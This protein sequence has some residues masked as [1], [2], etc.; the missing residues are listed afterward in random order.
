[1]LM[2]NMSVNSVMFLLFTKCVSRLLQHVSHRLS[3]AALSW[4]RTPSTRSGSKA[5][6]SG[7]NIFLMKSLFFFFKSPTVIQTTEVLK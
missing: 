1:M 6:Y 3:S 4:F 7:L 5:T 2:N